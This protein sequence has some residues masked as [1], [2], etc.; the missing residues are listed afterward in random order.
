[1]VTVAVLLA[2]KKLTGGGETP[3]ASASAAPSAAVPARAP[4]AVCKVEGQRVWAA[5]ANQRAGMTATALGDRIAI[6]VAIGYRAAVLVFDRNGEG[7]LVYVGAPAGSPFAKGVPAAQGERDLHRITPTANAAGQVFAYADY[8][9]LYKSKHRRIACEA[10]AA[11]AS[12]FAYDGKALIDPDAKPAPKPD[13]GPVAATPPP[14]ATPPPGSAAPGNPFA[15]LGKLKLKAAPSKDAPA[16]PAETTGKLREIR[17][18]RSFVDAGGKDVWA[19]GS[20][21]FGEKR[22][23]G[24]VGWK[25]RFVVMPAHGHEPL[26]MHQVDLPDPPGTLY[27]LESPVAERLADG[28]YVVAGRYRGSLH[29]WTLGSGKQRRSGPRVYR[30]GS[31]TLP[32][33]IPDGLDFLLLVSQEVS[34]DRYELRFGRIDG[35]KAALPALLERPPIEGVASMAEPTVGRIGNQRWLSYHG[36]KRREGE[37]VIVPVNAQLSATGRPYTVTRAD[38]TAYESGL[39]GLEGGKLLVVY[40]R[41]A[42]GGPELVS[43]TLTCEVKP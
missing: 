1:M 40:L 37:L 11:R 33:F 35:Q 21:L 26:V 8:R 24:R 13:A 43:E 42:G 23:G 34:D 27:T 6:G 31:P 22:E 15:V 20:E 28:S 30:G 7:N 41:N 16:A 38:Q 32:H 29:A 19:I 18:C 2:C 39:F 14:S 36:G 12:L 25:M 4:D 10:V 17:D 5:G 3:A 9:D